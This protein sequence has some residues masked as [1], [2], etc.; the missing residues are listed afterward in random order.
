MPNVLEFP[1]PGGAVR[2]PHRPI[3]PR[4]PLPTTAGKRGEY[5]LADVARPLSM[6]HRPVRAIIDALRALHLHDGMP[7]PRTPRIV[8]GKPIHGAQM[9]CR[10]SRWDAGEFDAWLEGRGPASPAPALAQPIRR[11]MAARAAKLALVR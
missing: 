8:R 11:E 3:A 9:I 10:G 5:A 7:L 2:P 6:L 1:Q 4:V